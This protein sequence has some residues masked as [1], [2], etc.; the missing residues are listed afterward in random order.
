MRPEACLHVARSSARVR[1]RAHL[2]NKDDLSPHDV[3]GPKSEFIEAYR[4]NIRRYYRLLQT[5]LTELER[6][7]VQRRLAEERAALRNLLMKTNARLDRRPPE[8]AVC[9]SARP[10]RR[11]AEFGPMINDVACEF[12]KP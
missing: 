7:F 6:H 11:S 1:A 9:E 8:P 2:N 5:P 4:E 3:A 12:D 10:L